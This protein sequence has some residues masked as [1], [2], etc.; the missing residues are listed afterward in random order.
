MIDLLLDPFASSFTQRAAV[1]CLLVALLAPSIGV[2]IIHRQLSYVADAMSHSTLVGV[3]LA[4]A[5][6]GRGAILIGALA[7]GL[8]VT[9]IIAYFAQMSTLPR[10][11]VI[12]VVASGFFASG[13][14][15]LSRV[16][17]N[18]SLNHLLFGQLLTVTST[19]LGITLVLVVIVLAYVTRNFRDLTF[20]TLDPLHARQVGI[21]V[22]RQTSAIL[23]LIAM[24]V[25]VCISAIGIVLT[26]S[27]L[28]G[29]AL[30]AR[31]LTSTIAQQVLAGTGLA[32]FQVFT[33]FVVSHHL[34]IAPGPT[35]AVLG[36]AIFFLTHLVASLMR[37][38]LRMTRHARR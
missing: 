36:T 31:L 7:A 37:T 11:A 29:P 22:A 25:V 35:I 10:D 26:V 28:I 3:A 17:T 19:D 4:F 5:W 16:D 15:A 2:W 18:I 8:T 14:I 1:V 33:G 34:S 27:L 9:L 32:L 24:S 38:D 13:I 12:A 30:S 23:A 20:V 21:A 6:F